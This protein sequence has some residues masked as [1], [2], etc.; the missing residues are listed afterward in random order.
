MSEVEHFKHENFLSQRRLVGF[1]LRQEIARI[2]GLP[3]W[4]GGDHHGESLIK[5]DGL[6]VALLV[7]KKG[8]RLAEHRNKESFTVHV[9][10]GEIAFIAEGATHRLTPGMVLALEHMIPHT[11]EAVEDAAFLL[12]VGGIAA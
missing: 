3:A 4:I 8:A 6:N 10:E 7:F 2:K 1:D 9:L 12:T 5:T 11:V